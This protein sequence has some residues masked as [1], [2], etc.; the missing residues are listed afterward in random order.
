MSTHVKPIDYY[1]HAPIVVANI[2]FIKRVVDVLYKKI[3]TQPLSDRVLQKAKPF[4]M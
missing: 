3:R 1:S 2:S 4:S